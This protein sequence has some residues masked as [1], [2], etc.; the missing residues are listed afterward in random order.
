MLQEIINFNGNTTEKTK[1]V[2][3][4]V[5]LIKWY[6]KEDKHEILAKTRKKENVKKLTAIC[7]KL[8]T[9]DV[10]EYWFYTVTVC[11]EIVDA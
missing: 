8:N 5:A 11:T 9:R 2:R 10:N 7:R 4:Y 1:K 6:L 3:K